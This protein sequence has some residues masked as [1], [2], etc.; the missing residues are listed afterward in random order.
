[1]TGLA[2]EILTLEEVAEY[3]K[4]SKRTIYSMAQKGEIPAFKFGGSGRFRRQE[5]DAWIA[6]SF[7]AT[8]P[9]KK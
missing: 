7:K 3:L 9:T 1:M 6:E 8:V 4:A 2:S 5:L